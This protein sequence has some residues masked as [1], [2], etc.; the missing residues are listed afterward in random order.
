MRSAVISGIW[1]L[2]GSFSKIYLKFVALHVWIEH[3]NWMQFNSQSEWQIFIFF[4][5]SFLNT[6]MKAICPKV[7]PVSFLIKLHYLEYKNFLPLLQTEKSVSWLSL[8]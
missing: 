7:L 2:D 6:I 4:S 5:V 1:N 3:L 8:A